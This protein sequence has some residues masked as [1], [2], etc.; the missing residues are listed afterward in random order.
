MLLCDFKL[1]YSKLAYAHYGKHVVPWL[2]LAFLRHQF[3]CRQTSLSPHMLFFQYDNEFPVFVPA[4]CKIEMPRVLA[5]AKLFTRAFLSFIH[6]LRTKPTKLHT[7]W[8]RL[9]ILRQIEMCLH[10]LQWTGSKFGICFHKIRALQ[11]NGAF[12]IY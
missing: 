7:W 3:I 4:V 2:S 9:F 1:P 5:R 6:G 8:P 12:C 10:L 11:V